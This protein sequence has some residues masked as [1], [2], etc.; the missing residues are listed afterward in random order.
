[1]IVA[2]GPKNKQ[3]GLQPFPTAVHV[4]Y[5]AN[6]KC[7]VLELVSQHQHAEEDRTRLE[8]FLAVATDAVKEE[9]AEQP[10]ENDEA[11]AKTEGNG[12]GKRQKRTG[13]S[14]GAEKAAALM[15]AVATIYLLLSI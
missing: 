5:W 4:P 7:K 15:T 10:A 8:A 6:Q 13:P 1:V 2:W 9:D 12:H 11:D 3:L 14:G